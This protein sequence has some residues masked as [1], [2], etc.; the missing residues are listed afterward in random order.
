MNITRNQLLTSLLSLFLLGCNVR[1]DRTVSDS[2]KSKQETILL[3]S[4]QKL[5]SLVSKNKAK[6]ADVSLE[7]A[8]R[9]GSLAKVINTPAARAKAYNILGN[10]YSVISIDSGFYFYHK[11]LILSDSFHLTDRKGK[12][13]YNLGVLNRSAGHYRNSIM[14]LDSALRFSISANDFSTMSNSLNL[15]GGFYYSIG[16][17]GKAHKMFDSAYTVAKSK[18]LYLQMGSALGNLARFELDPKKSIE[19]SKLAISYM[20][21]SSSSDEAIAMILINIGYRFSESDSAIHYYNKAVNMVSADCAPEVIIAGYN[22][23]AYCYLDKRDFKNALKCVEQ[24]A[25]PV[26]LR[27]HNIDWQPA[28]Y[29]TYADVLEGSGRSIEAKAMRNKSFAVKKEYQESVSVVLISMNNK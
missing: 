3:D 13:L 4:L 23:M 1:S 10:A 22:N 7:Y 28:V 16:E 20:E 24:C 12:V 17:N 14:F 8:K 18:S 5:D 9:A 29:D 2:P 27:T 26:A 6:N 25:L 19:L 15:I 21:R 11:A